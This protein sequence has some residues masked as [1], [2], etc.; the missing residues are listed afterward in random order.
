MLRHLFPAMVVT[1][2]AAESGAQPLAYGD[3][4]A[5]PGPTLADA[6]DVRLASTW[7]QRTTADEAC[8]NGGGEIVA[9]TLQRDVDGMYRGRLDRRTLIL[10]CGTHG[11][12]GE[13]CQLTLEGSGKVA[14]SGAVVADET[15]PSGSALR[16]S[17][18]PLPGHTASASGACSTGFMRAIEAMY[19]SVTHGVEF[20]VP[21]A[22]AG[23]RVERLED[24]G[25]RVEVA[26]R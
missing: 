22:G 7:P 26:G 18:H 21:A 13:G 6:Y 5:A 17:W 11:A 25:W 14:M 10:F 8:R 19:R 15:S 12:S 23:R 24:Y 4:A 9:G 2:L 1:A 3:A 20:A 16:L